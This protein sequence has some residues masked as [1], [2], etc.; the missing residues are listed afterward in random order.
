MEST[1]IYHSSPHTTK[2]LLFHCSPIQ[3]TFHTSQSSTLAHGPQQRP[4][5]AF[6]SYSAYIPHQPK[7]NPRPWSTTKALLLH[8]S[9]IQPTFHTSQSTTL[10]H[11]PQQRPYCCILLLFSLQTN[12]PHQPKSNALTYILTSPAKVQSSTRHCY[13]QWHYTCHCLQ[14]TC[15]P[16]QPKCSAIVR[17]HVLFCTVNIYSGLVFSLQ[18]YIPAKVQP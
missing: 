1:T 16:P 15:I 10:A 6:F 11:G 5:V 8:S 17:Y 3:P 7:C 12:I 9:P 4:I 2:A 13:T 18:T 14:L